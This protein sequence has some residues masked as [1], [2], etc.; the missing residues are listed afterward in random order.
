M[1]DAIKVAGAAAVGAG[2]GFLVGYK[3]LEKRLAQAFDERLAEETKD[4]REVYQNL[5]QPYSSP[6]AAVEALVA[7]EL[8][9]DPRVK[10]GKTAYHKVEPKIDIPEQ[11]AAV[12]TTPGPIVSNVFDSTKPRLITQDEFMENEPEH[13]Q[14]TLTY[15]EKDDQLTG[16][17]D[18][19]IDNAE[20]VVGTEY[21]TKFGW[22][23]SDEHTVHIRNEGL[24]M[25]FE[26]VRSER[27]YE[28]EVGVPPDQSIPPHKRVGR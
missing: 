18:D 9:K 7:P 26:V 10:N 8:A 5:R 19:P 25:D 20:L 27:S 1:N 14:A 4:M 21:K 23:S 3:L 22:E 16:E 15:Y 11:P 6:E 12:V 24:H 13:E 28:E 17:K 2:L